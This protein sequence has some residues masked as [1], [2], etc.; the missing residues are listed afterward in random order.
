MFDYLDE[1]EFSDEFR[2]EVNNNNNESIYNVEK[3]LDKCKR[4]GV[5]YYYVKWEGFDSSSNTW[6]PLS[7]L[8]NVKQYIQEYEDRKIAD[9]FN[10]N[11]INTIKILLEEENKNLLTN[12][13]MKITSENEEHKNNITTCSHIINKISNTSA[14]TDISNKTMCIIIYY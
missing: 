10:T 2:N 6:E 3:I 14:S 9:E 13:S 4:N 11:H 7:N 5:V 8:K 12:C 1:F